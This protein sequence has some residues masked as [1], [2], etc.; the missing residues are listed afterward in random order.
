M[1]TKAKSL[2]G[3]VAVTGAGSIALGIMSLPPTESIWV[4]LVLIVLCGAAQAVSVPLFAS[5]SVSLAFAISF[6]SLLLF[7]PAGAIL[8]NLGSAAVHAFYPRR[9]AWYKMV[10]NAGVFTTS[11]AAAASAYALAGGVWPVRDLLS[12]VVPAGLAAVIYFWLN[13]SLVALALTLTTGASFRTVFNENHRWLIPQYLTIASITLMAAVG[14]QSM[15]PIALVA[16]S[17][18]LIMPWTSAR[19]YV[20]QTR[21]IIARNSELVDV[22]DQLER[23][24]TNL[25]QRIEQM[26]TLYRVGLALNQSLELHEM[27]SCIVN[28]LKDLLPAHGVAVFLYDAQHEE[29]ILTEHVGLSVQYLAHPEPSLDG[30]ATRAIREKRRFVMDGAS[31]NPDLLS[32]A[33]ANEGVVAAICLPLI[34]GDEVVGALDITFSEPHIFNDNEFTLME[35]FAEQTAAGIRSWQLNQQV[36]GSYLS[37]IAALVATV[38]AKDPYTRG[39]SERVRDL[40]L[41]IGNQMGL[42]RDDVD[43]LELAALFHDIGKIGIPESILGK[44]DSLTEEEWQSIRRHP[45]IAGAILKHIPR[46]SGTIPIIRSHHERPDGAGYPDGISGGLPTLSA[47]IAVADSYDAMTSDRPYRLAKSKDFAIS[48]LK[49]GAGSQFDVRVVE[50]AIQ[51]LEPKARTGAQLHVLEL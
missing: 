8:A 43:T 42:S 30:P 31:S 26:G 32:Q 27:L 24:N 29:L 37:T 38:E 22:N 9:R 1:N 21:T 33:A 41:S 44:K 12:A 23:A 25:Q 18:P 50:A 5:S 7:G 35:T 46:L 40:A 28:S 4:L 48:Q 49:G 39:H 2:I 34:A 47:I 19:M 11:A 13:T 17:L 16:F 3:V 36:H 6:V 20:A 14:Y 15:G 10:F 45:S 51:V